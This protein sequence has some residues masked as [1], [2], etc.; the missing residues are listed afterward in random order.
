MAKRLGQ[1]D[2]EAVLD[3]HKLLA[4]NH[5]QTFSDPA[6]P[7]ARLAPLKVGIHRDLCEK[8]P[9]VS[10]KTIRNF[11]NGYVYHPAYLRLTAVAQTNRIDLE[12]QVSGVVTEEQA[13]HS[14]ALMEKHAAERK[15]RQQS[16]SA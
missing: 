9:D 1:Q 2:R 16:K 4:K 14:L 10:K 12:G 3:F 11:V 5:P 8:Y 15:A 13:Q 6:S 7:V